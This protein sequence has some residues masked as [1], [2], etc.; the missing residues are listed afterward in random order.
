MA[1]NITLSFKPTSQPQSEGAKI[2]GEMYN[3]VR[4]FHEVFSHPI[5]SNE[6][7]A[8]MLRL[9]ANLIREEAKE[10]VAALENADGLEILDA[11][12][13]TIY[14]LAGTLVMINGALSHALAFD[15]FGMS[16]T[17]KVMFSFES[18]FG[19]DMKKAFDHSLYIASEI[20]DIAAM[21]DKGKGE[22]AA[23]DFEMIPAAIS[24]A[25]CLLSSVLK[26]TGVDVKEMVA[27]IHESNMTKLWSGDALTR[28][29]QVAKCKYNPKDLA[30]RTCLSRQGM[31]GYRI[32][33]GKIL[34]CPDYT[35]VNLD[36]FLTACTELS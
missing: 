30:F 33:D 28:Q 36:S 15:P 20:D 27:A 21:M 18:D 4:E 29:A 32:S 22:L 17:A 2:V 7:T 8:D 3:M 19:G 1:K 35:S 12:G 10:G 26:S 25:I 14:V 11:A 23:R 13:D 31:I 5:N 9:R 6:I 16:M 34:K 24:D